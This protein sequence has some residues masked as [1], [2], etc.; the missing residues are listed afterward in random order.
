MRADPRRP[1]RRRARGATPFGRPAPEET[2][3]YRQWLRTALQV[4]LTRGINLV[5]GSSSF[6]FTIDAVDGAVAADSSQVV[7]VAVTVSAR[8]SAEAPSAA[9]TLSVQAASSG[10]PSARVAVAASARAPGIS[11][12]CCSRPRSRR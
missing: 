6:A 1:P 11:S 12:G 2:D 9:G 4:L 10:S 5:I 7:S 8:G 3:R